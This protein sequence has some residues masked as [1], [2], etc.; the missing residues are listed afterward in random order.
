M[1]DDEYQRNQQPQ[2]DRPPQEQEAMLAP[3]QRTRRLPRRARRSGEPRIDQAGGQGESEK[4]ANPKI[5][6]AYKDWITP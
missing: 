3:E 4:D 5:P 1:R 6:S 2:P